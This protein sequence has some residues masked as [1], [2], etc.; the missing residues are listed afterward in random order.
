LLFI[1]F[2]AKTYKKGNAGKKTVEEHAAH[3][4][5]ASKKKGGKSKKV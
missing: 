3:A 1:N 5:G 4:N 2:Y